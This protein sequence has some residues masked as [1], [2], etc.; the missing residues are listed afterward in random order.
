MIKEGE[1]P[2]PPSEPRISWARKRLPFEEVRSPLSGNWIKLVLFALLAICCAAAAG[3]VALVLHMPLTDM[4]VV[5]PA[6]GALWFV[7]R[8]FMMLNPRT[9]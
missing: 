4:R 3:Y 2:P 7:L 1:T 9:R 5:A 8:I 6:I